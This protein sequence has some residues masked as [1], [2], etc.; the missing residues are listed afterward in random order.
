VEVVEEDPAALSSSLTANMQ[1][2]SAGLDELMALQNNDVAK[3]R[4][5]YQPRRRNGANPVRFCCFV[6]EVHLKYDQS[7]RISEHWWI[8]GELH[9]G[10]TD[11]NHMDTELNHIGTESHHI[12]TEWNH[13]G[14]ES[15]H[16][17][18][19]SHHTQTELNHT[20]TEPH[21]TLALNRSTLALI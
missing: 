18:T 5:E 15:H 2:I 21:T 7:F 20:G 1:D 14:S 8:T 17:D 16:V 3:V 4:K 13:I 19:E 9:H 6:C 11:V 10:G 12:G